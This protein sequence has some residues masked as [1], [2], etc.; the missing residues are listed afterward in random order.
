[1]LSQ[2]L[3]SETMANETADS[4]LMSQTLLGS[5]RPAREGMGSEESQLAINLIKVG[6]IYHYVRY[7][8][9]VRKRDI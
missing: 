6:Y 5:K 9:Y 8:L 1:M 3:A 4:E 7:G 2:T